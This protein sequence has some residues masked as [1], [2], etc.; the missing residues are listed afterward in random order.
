MIISAS[1]RTDIPAVYADWFFHR[2]KEGYVL[3]PNPMNPHQ[4]SRISLN[5]SVIDGI[6][7]WTKNPI[8]ML[9]RLRELDGYGRRFYFTITITPY[10]KDV[11]PHI[12]SKEDE[13]IPS[14]IALSKVLGKERVCWRYDPVLISGKYN[15]EFHKE[16]FHRLASLLGSYTEKCTISFLD[17]YTK[18]QKN[19]AAIGA[20]EP[21]PEEQLELM[22]FFVPIAQKYG[23]SIDTCCEERD[24][25]A[26]GIL[27]AHCIDKNRL[28]RI[29][30]I[31]L[32]VGKDE[33]QRPSCGCFSSI[34]IGSYDTCTNGCLYC[35]A[36]RDGLLAESSFARHDPSSPLLIG[37]SGP[38]DKIT[39]RRMKSLGE[40]V[41]SERQLDLW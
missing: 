41:H 3:V 10:G 4:L 40:S 15:M 33:N 11:E 18:I 35:Y 29:G 14:F 23:I 27:H 26:L 17:R 36:N 34:D 38:L 39:E 19:M 12:P 22:R 16:S 2:V 9:P 30:A 25:S 20:L 24:F 1:R 6:V 37:K 32:E 28:E 13:I 21:S 7:F 5:P 8:P 31:K